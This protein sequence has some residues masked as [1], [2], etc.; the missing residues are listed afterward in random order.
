MRCCVRRPRTNGFRRCPGARQYLA[1]GFQIPFRRRDRAGL[2]QRTVTLGLQ[3]CAAVLQRDDRCFE[4]PDRV[5][6]VQTHL[7]D[8]DVAAAGLIQPQLQ[9]PQ[10]KFPHRQR[11]TVRRGTVLRG[12][13]CRGSTVQGTYPFPLHPLTPGL[14][15][16]CG[17][18]GAQQ[19]QGDGLVTVAE[20][21]PR[22]ALVGAELGDQ[23]V[24]RPA[25][26]DLPKPG[27][28]RIALRAPTRKRPVTPP[29]PNPCLAPAGHAHTPSPVPVQA[30]P[31]RTT[32]LSCGNT[33][34]QSWTTDRRSRLV[35]HPHTPPHHPGSRAH[36]APQPSD[37]GHI[38]T[39]SDHT[40]RTHIARR[41]RPDHEPSPQAAVR[42]PG[43]RRP[44]TRLR[45][46]AL[47]HLPR[48]G[49]A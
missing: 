6:V 49:S 47:R 1:E 20:L 43:H 11:C 48:V 34:T 16:Q 33:A 15:D 46:R 9:V 42:T 37:H 4:D 44:H 24:Q 35:L 39:T 28:Q 10:L 17:D 23:L 27:S 2:A 45:R 3:L 5:F 19:A 32:P 8:F 22:G 38:P 30:R 25:R 31:P 12:R 36:I 41:R 18:H 29:S 26:G 14:G 40:S 7:L 21:S 13:S